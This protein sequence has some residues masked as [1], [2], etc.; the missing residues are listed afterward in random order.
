MKIYTLLLL[1]S[2]FYVTQGKIKSENT[3][4]FHIR[5][6]KDWSDRNSSLLVFKEVLR[7]FAE[8]DPDLELTLD[9]EKHSSEIIEQYLF[10]DTE[11]FEFTRNGYACIERRNCAPEEDDYTLMIK[12]AHWDA[13][14]VRK[15][16][17]HP[18]AKKGYEGFE[19]DFYTCGSKQTYVAEVDK[20]SKSM[21]GQEVKKLE[22]YFPAVKDKLPVTKNDTLIVAGQRY[23]WIWRLPDNKLKDTSFDIDVRCRY[24]S[25]YD[26]DRG[27]NCQGCELVY[28]VES[29]DD[30]FGKGTADR[31]WS[32]FQLSAATFPHNCRCVDV[33]DPRFLLNLDGDEFLLPPHH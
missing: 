18:S 15:F 21:V 1:L 25:L 13:D 28:M 26:A 16:L 29:E 30:F 8:N 14:V 6:T 3:K 32:L 5:F 4:E 23:N 33:A 19:H 22:G 9:K 31:M 12:Y 2:L 7:I 24:R 11:T 17:V 10:L 27:Y 20:L